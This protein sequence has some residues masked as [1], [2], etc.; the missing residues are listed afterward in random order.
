MHLPSI[1]AASQWRARLPGLAL[2]TLA[3]LSSLATSQAYSPVTHSQA[4]KFTLGGTG[5]ASSRW[6]VTLKPTDGG[7]LQSLRQLSFYTTA[8]PPSALD[9]AAR[10]CPSLSVAGRVEGQPATIFASTVAVL[11]ETS[12]GADAP[13]WFDKLP[14]SSTEGVLTV[15]FTLGSATS[16]PV[17]IEWDVSASGA[18]IDGKEANSDGALRIEYELLA[19]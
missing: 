19:P 10:A 4:P 12:L 1:P 16:T 7:Q 3:G 11:G 14:G 9:C 18:V 8:T 17:A 2:L 6:R 13:V 5:P 15:D